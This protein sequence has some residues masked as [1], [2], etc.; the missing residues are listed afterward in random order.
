M[1]TLKERPPRGNPARAC[2]GGAARRPTVASAVGFVLKGY[3][4]LSES[5]IAQEILALE[6]RGLVIRLHALRRPAESATH[7]VH[8]AIAAPVRYLP[9][10]LHREPARV[11]R[12]WRA[13]RDTT[14]YA[15]ARRLWRADFARDRTRGR[16]RR[17]GQALVLAHELSPDTGRLHAHFLHTPASVARYAAALRR[18]PWSVSAHAKD[19]WTSPTWELSEKLADCA[20]ATTC[21]EANRR[22]LAGLAPPGRVALVY[23]GL[24]LER[25]PPPEPR[26]PRD[27][28][29][30]ADPVR[31]L[32]VGRAVEKKGYDD[33][34]AALA[35]LPETLAWR[36]DHIGGGAL[37]GRLRAA[38]HARGIGGRIVW[39]GPRPQG[40]VLRAF[41]SA[42]LF[43]LACRAAADG[44]RDGLPNVLMEAQS[45]ELAVVSTRFSAI[46]ELVRDGAT[47]RLVAPGDRPGLARAIAALAAA[48]SLRARLGRAGRERVHARF[49]LDACIEPLAARFGLARAAA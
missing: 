31:F 41:R 34:L 49:A 46:P 11:L 25:F 32:S 19:I 22:H 17:F 20:W 37:L 29:D 45:Q 10:Y 18:I 14:G 24:D 16:V 42:D 38:A 28:S 36:L 12:A 13:L 33:L 15:D 7:P 6:R 30:P 35:A 5:F 40:F 9:E 27:G 23:H 39:H 8:D 48:P 3:P 4:R 43:L 47:G 2:R 1:R 44:D 26:P 21:T